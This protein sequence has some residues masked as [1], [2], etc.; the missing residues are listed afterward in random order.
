MENTF[1]VQQIE[2]KENFLTHTKSKDQSIKCT[3]EDTQPDGS[4]SFLD[5]L[6]TPET[7]RTLTIRAYRKPTHIDQ[8]SQWG[9]YHHIA[10]YSIINTVCHRTKTVPHQNTLIPE[11]W[12]NVIPETPKSRINQNFNII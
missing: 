8:C 7:N 4:I 2:H 10:K 11:K 6:I 3:V 5:S 12:G 9:S 1:I